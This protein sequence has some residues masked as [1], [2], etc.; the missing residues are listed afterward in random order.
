MEVGRIPGVLGSFCIQIGP[1]R[2]AEESGQGPPPRHTAGGDEAVSWA[3][4]FERCNWWVIQLIS[5]LLVTLQSATCRRAVSDP[6]PGCS[7]V[8]LA[9]RRTL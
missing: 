8:G 2:V 9:D 3:S 1:R 7:Q 6:T 4:T 5:S